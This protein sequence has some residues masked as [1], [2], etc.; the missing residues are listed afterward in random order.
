[1]LE[2]ELRRLSLLEGVLGEGR[3][4]VEVDVFGGDGGRFRPEQSEIP[5]LLLVVVL[6]LLLLM[7]LVLLLLQMLLTR[8]LIRDELRV[9]PSTVRLTLGLR[10]TLTLLSLWL[11]IRHLV[12]QLI[13]TSGGEKSEEGER[14]TS[15]A[16]APSFCSHPLKAENDELIPVLGRAATA[17]P[18]RANPSPIHSAVVSRPTPTILIFFAASPSPTTARDG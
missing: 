16:L 9:L 4:A 2:L 7:L 6:L 5:L 11:L 18:A 8:R 10:L 14:E 3:V 12:L 15:D 17:E 1:M 13:Q